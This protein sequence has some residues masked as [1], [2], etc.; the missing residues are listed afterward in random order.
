MK[1]KRKPRH[2]G[3][4][5]REVYLEPF[6]GKVS[7][8][9]I[10]QHLMVSRSTFNRLVNEEADLSPEM[11]L[12]LSSVLGGEPE[13]WLAMQSAYTLWETRQSMDLSKVKPID[14]SSY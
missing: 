14:L 4:F 6:A 5:I 3:A 8:S 7:R 10:A 2:P 13:K 12:R 11:A 1:S 9:V